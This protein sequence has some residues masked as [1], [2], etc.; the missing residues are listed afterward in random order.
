MV[1]SL[2]VRLKNEKSL[3]ARASR[4]GLVRR[5]KGARAAV[6]CVMRIALLS[7][8]HANEIAIEAV[9]ADIA[10]HGV[11]R[12]VCLGDTAALGPRPTQVLARL[13]DLP[14]S[15][16]LG[17]HDAFMLDQDLIH[18]YDCAPAIVQAVQWCRAQ[19]SAEDLRFIGSFVPTLE[20]A[21]EGGARLLA[22]HGTPRSHME[23]LLPTT[24]PEALD[25]LFAEHRAAVM[26]G[27]H[28]H[29][30]ML[31]QHKG[32]LLVNPGSVGL[33]F[34]QYAGGKPPRILSHAEWAC[35]ESRPS[36]ITVSLHRL[37]LDRAALAAAARA[38][39]N[40]FCPMLVEQY[41]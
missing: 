37:S 40:P 30:P 41:A 36:G 5:G 8:L 6:R 17:N 35:V 2:A 12:M 34:E 38:S 9:L 26:A 24:P 13:R 27:G 7:D 4:L 28:T 31:R 23:D 21:L 39:D 11:D 18:T 32:M 22:F 20:I 29:V 19:L 1:E 25:D 3:V 33:A 16:I 15:Y 10:R 14:C